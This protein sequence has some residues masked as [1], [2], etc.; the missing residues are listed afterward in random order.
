MRK[1]ARQCDRKR[2]MLRLRKPWNFRGKVM[3][4]KGKRVLGPPGFEP[5]TK[6]L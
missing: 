1:R 5:G 3:I 2:M 6:G 4:L